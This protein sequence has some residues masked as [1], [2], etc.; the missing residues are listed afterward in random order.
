[1]AIT[2]PLPVK[3]SAH[4]SRM[5]TSTPAFPPRCPVL[6]RCHCDANSGSLGS[7]DDDGCGVSRN[8]RRCRWSY[9]NHTTSRLASSQRSMRSRQSRA[10]DRGAT[11]SSANRC[12]DERG[13]S[14]DCVLAASGDTRRVT[15]TRD[16]TCRIASSSRGRV[17][18]RSAAAV[19]MAALRDSSPSANGV[20][21]TSEAASW[22]SYCCACSGVTRTI[23]W[24]RCERVASGVSGAASS[25]RAD[26]TMRTTTART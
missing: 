1:M 16:E 22:R 11:S 6:R 19:R 7:V 8:C 20:R 24:S 9:A 3:P 4:A 18:A 2:L 14:D 25:T 12:S 26:V 5:L 15:R 21:P 23:Q 13:V 17:V 10:A